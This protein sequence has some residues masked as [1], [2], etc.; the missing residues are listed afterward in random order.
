LN[1][2]IELSAQSIKSITTATTDSEKGTPQGLIRLCLSSY[3]E[4]KSCLPSFDLF[5]I[6]S[7]DLAFSKKTIDS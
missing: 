7:V 2:W 6:E 1:H 4:D 5:A 3:D